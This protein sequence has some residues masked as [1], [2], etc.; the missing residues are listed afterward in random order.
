MEEALNASVSDKFAG[1]ALS[2]S[3]AEASLKNDSR[4]RE[5]FERNNIQGL[6]GIEN[7]INNLE[8]I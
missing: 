2:G 6:A 8:A 3:Q 5:R 1:L 7:A 4:N